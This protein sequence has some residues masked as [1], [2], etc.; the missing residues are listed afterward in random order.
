MLSLRQLHVRRYQR[1]LKFSDF[2]A[3]LMVIRAEDLLAACLQE[4]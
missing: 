1:H 3:D 2:P 4:R